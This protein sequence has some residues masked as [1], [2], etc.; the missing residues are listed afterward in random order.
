MPKSSV[1]DNNKLQA[2]VRKLAPKNKRTSLF[3]LTPN[4]PPSKIIIK[5]LTKTLHLIKTSLNI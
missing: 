2:K 3:N 5:N 4:K 1:K